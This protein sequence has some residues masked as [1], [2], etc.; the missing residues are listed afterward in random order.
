[1]N[2][3]HGLIGKTVE[4]RLSES[5]VELIHRGQRIAAHARSPIRGSFT[6]LEA[7]RPERLATTSTARTS[8]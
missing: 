3:P 1:M 5:A 7:D 4:V 8:G 2:A 6:T